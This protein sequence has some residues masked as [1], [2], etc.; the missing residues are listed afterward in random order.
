MGKL[1]VNWGIRQFLANLVNDLVTTSV[2]KALTANQG[3]ILKDYFDSIVAGTTIVGNSDLLDGFH[4]SYFAKLSDTFQLYTH[5][6]SGTQH[7]VVGASTA[8]FVRFFATA[9]FVAGDTFRVNTTVVNVYDQQGKPF[10]S[11]AF[12]KNMKVLCFYNG[13]NSLY[14]MNS[15]SSVVAD[16]L[17]GMVV[18]TTNLTPGVSALPSGTFHITYE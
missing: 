9:N 12:V 1:N 18:N 3:K 16:T 10:V 8:G 11:N 4:A 17:R 13:S 7:T 14:F 5:T 2:T 6:R 15:G